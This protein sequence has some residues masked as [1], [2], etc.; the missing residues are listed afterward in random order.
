MTAKS[1]ALL[2]VGMM[3]ISGVFLFFHVDYPANPAK[4]VLHFQPPKNV[5]PPKIPKMFQNQ[6]FNYPGMYLNQTSFTPTGNTTIILQ[7]YAYNA[8]SGAPIA[9]QKL[10]VFVQLAFGNTT[11]NSKGY[12]RITLLQSG[13]GVFAFSMFQFDPLFLRLFIS[14]TPGAMWK[15]LSFNPAEK[16]SVSGIT[17]SHGKNVGN[18]KISTLTLLGGYSTV[19][20]STGYY[21]L[22]MVNDTYLILVNKSGF[23]PLPIPSAIN[24]TGSQIQN[25]NLD[26]QV[27]KSAP[28]YYI[29]GYVFNDLK[30]PIA[31][32]EVYSST[33]N[34][35]V[36]TNAAGYYNITAA[37]YLNTLVFSG[38][39]YNKLQQTVTVFKNITNYNVT[40]SSRN[41]FIAPPQN[42]GITN[43]SLPVGMS[44]NSSA[45]HY[46]N[47][48]PTHPY[49][50]GQV[51]LYSPLM[52]V[53]NSQFLIYTSVNGT[54]FYDRITTGPAGNYSIDTSYYGNYNFT[55]VSSIFNQT[56]K[57]TQISGPKSN[58]P[59]YVNT[60]PS[61]IFSAKGKIQN[62]LNNSL[63]I[64]GAT[65]NLTSGIGSPTLTSFTSQSNGNYTITALMG[66]YSLNISAPG[67]ISHNYLLI[68]NGN[69]TNQNYNLTPDFNPVKGASVWNP[70]QGSGIPGA[71][72]GNITNQINS[73]Q[74][75]YNG[76]P[77]STTNYTPFTLTLEFVNIT[78]SPIKNTSFAI[79]IEV[80]S[81][82][83]TLINTTNQTGQY[84]IT[85]NYG[86]TFILV[87][88]MI[89]YSNPGI[90]INTS[91]SSTNSPLI[92]NMSLLKL[93]HLNLT[94]Y[95]PFGVYNQST[96]YPDNLTSYGY[97]L[98]IFAGSNYTNVNDNY[99][100]INFSLPNGLYKFN[101]ISSHFV[102]TNF[103]VNI[104]GNNIS[105]SKTINPYVLNL[106][107][108][109]SVIWGYNI[110]SS[111][112][113]KIY[114]I[115]MN[116]PPKI[117]HAVISLTAGSF[118]LKTYLV[119]YS[120]NTYVNNTN[121][122]LNKT[123]FNNTSHFATTNGSSNLSTIYVW[124]SSGTLYANYTSTPT[125]NLYISQ[126]Y[127]NL[128]L[129]NGKTTL[130]ENSVN[131]TSNENYSNHYFNL[132]KFFLSTS[133]GTSLSITS[134]NYQLPTPAPATANI[135]LRYYTT[136]LK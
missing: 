110:S 67:Y 35:K 54:Y 113:G 14:S 30:K 117:G 57:N 80:N 112:T 115:N 51:L 131:F 81:L 13:T 85:F 109:T 77:P 78:N 42:T 66:N 44:D 49:L 34:T 83:F 126:I 28:A 50:S 40:L 136:T 108:N 104:S 22:N 101:Y 92:V 62:S 76:V 59:I 120:N 4:L 55:I 127:I 96:I 98:P 123:K 12:Y 107:W 129:T 134:Y 124:K 33:L 56:Y 64:D 114:S 100:L 5:K 87:P 125:S 21:S 82:L 43:T 69:L 24:V 74:S 52:L 36:Y 25:Y 9:N 7:G 19:S 48:P 99:T 20:S 119:N 68:L 106:T 102:P 71:K 32:I 27:N 2:V 70:S 18:V 16:F 23:S 79:Y 121:F 31:N 26:L 118:T 116:M 73:T 60:T 3:V 132:T 122:A 61:Y 133:T 10:G 128:N 29:S 88:E 8:S 45:V 91:N 135:T 6:T 72:S 47:P 89:Q 97:V 111:N 15:N 53:P 11:T 84:S 75:K 130:Y 58:V 86:G 41:P 65:I 103:T 46:A 38:I 39:S 95:N 63:S 105:P 37:F 94:L 17:E 1:I 93:F 90:Y